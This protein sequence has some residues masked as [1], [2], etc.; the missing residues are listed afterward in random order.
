VRGDGDYKL[1]QAARTIIGALVI[2]PF[3]WLSALAI[4]IIGADE[5]FVLEG[6]MLH[7][8]KVA[9]TVLTVA[10]F[11]FAILLGAPERKP[12]WPQDRP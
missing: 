10:F 6:G 4:D 9:I 1:I 8:T 3:F 2:F 7:A 5:S 12:K 11:A